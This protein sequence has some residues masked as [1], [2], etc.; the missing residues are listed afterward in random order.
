ML[1]A[2]RCLPGGQLIPQVGALQ[3]IIRAGLSC[4]MNMHVGYSGAPGIQ[5][6]EPRD[7]ADAAGHT[8]RGYDES[9]GPRHLDRAPPASL[10]LYMSSRTYRKCC[11]LRVHVCGS[12]SCNSVESLAAPHR[13]YQL[14]KMLSTIGL[15]A[16]G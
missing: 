2:P 4:M 11:R 12:L 1:H 3:D 15:N 9:R 8:W 13:V 16:V 7:A 5:Q 6:L 14:S 10:D